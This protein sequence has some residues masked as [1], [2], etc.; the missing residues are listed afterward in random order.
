M[1]TIG[2]GMLGIGNVAKGT[3][4]TLEMNRK[5]IEAATGADLVI[6]RILNR[7]PQVNRGIDIPK[8]IYTAEVEDILQA[9]DIDIVVELIGGIEPAVTYMAE[10]LRNGKHVITANKAAIAAR[11]EYLQKLAM[12]NHVMLRFEASVAGGIPIINALT[13]PLLSNEISEI[14]G[15]LNGTTNY[16][17]T[18]MSRYGS[19]YEEALREAQEK[20]MAE[21]DP[22]ADVEGLDAANKLSILISLVFGCH[23]PPEKIPTQGIT[24][25]SSYDIEFAREF[26]YRVKLLAAAW[27]T[28]GRLSCSV[29]PSLIREDHPLAS[30]DGAF[31]AVFV[32]GNASGPLMFYGAGAGP[33]P[34][35]SAVMGDII[36][37]ARKM[38][39]CRAEDM[40]PM[41]H[42]EKDAYYEGEGE[43]GY[44]VRVDAPD[45]PGVL[46]NISATFGKY[47]IGI[48]STMQ[49][50]GSNSDTWLPIIFILYRVKRE[51]LD[52]AL[53][54]LLEK[55]YVRSVDCV[56]RV[57]K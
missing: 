43:N 57:E 7:R 34:T 16:I 15:I 9:P 54:E 51:T 2:I 6:R 33:L 48:E 38:V 14:S 4:R 42:Y 19:S 31:N 50:G 21:A 45:R 52:Q 29:E 3:Y 12:E 49:R 47:H 20:G 10:A 8:E 41:L 27:M 35:G 17:L 24:R 44:Y 53:E 11:G 55:G 25:V 22:T 30:V 26:H 36:E 40:L 18:G 46:G 1:K 39:Q 32:N 23:V 13:F 56:M 37:V 28:E 5:K